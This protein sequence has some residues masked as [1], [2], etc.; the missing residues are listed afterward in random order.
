MRARGLV[1]VVL[2]SGVLFAG[3]TTGPVSEPAPTPAFPLEELTIR[4]LQEA[5]S[6][7]RFTSRQLVEQYLRRVD[8]VDRGGP[9]LRSISDINPDARRI[10]DDL[11][12]ERRR[13]RVRGPLHGIPV[14]IK[15]NIDT[16]DRMPTTAGSL[17]LDGTIAPRDAFV[18]ERLRAAG[19]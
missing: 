18:V 2:A 1:A 14:V 12:A 7:G 8:Q 11:D 6:S 17:A 9:L 5:M 16:A 13:G 19:A 3:C 4:D 10:A 15:D